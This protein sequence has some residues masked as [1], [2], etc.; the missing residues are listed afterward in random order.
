MQEQPLEDSSTS[1]SHGLLSTSYSLHLRLDPRGYGEAGPCCVDRQQCVR[2]IKLELIPKPDASLGRL[3]NTAGAAKQDRNCRLCHVVH[4]R[5]DALKP[6][7]CRSQIKYPTARKYETDLKCSSTTSDFE[8]SVV[9]SSM[10]LEVGDL[11]LHS[12]EAEM[13]PSLPEFRPRRRKRI[14]KPSFST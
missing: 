3:E 9:F 1:K 5:D 7:I 14:W 13:L 11:S 10:L 8:C 12:S 2:T 4:R 6:P